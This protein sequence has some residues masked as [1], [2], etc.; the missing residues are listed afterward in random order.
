MVVQGAIEA[1]AVRVL[2]QYPV[3]RAALFGSAARG[4]MKPDSDIDMLV[5][6]FPGTI[7]I[8]F[9]GL[10]VDLEEA[11][12]RHVDLLTFD[13]LNDAKPSFKQAVEK[14]TRLFYER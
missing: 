12:G 2:S 9:F 7:G 3:Q 4:D 5:E 14:E 1:T 8:N 13:A 6:F 10:H 11:Y